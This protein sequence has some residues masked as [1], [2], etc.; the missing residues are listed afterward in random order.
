MKK[1][2]VYI[3]FDGKEFS[4]MTECELYE[5][6]MKEGRKQLNKTYKKL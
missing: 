1:K 4:K 3:A 2:T 6:R 5:E